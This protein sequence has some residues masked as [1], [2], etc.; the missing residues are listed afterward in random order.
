MKALKTVGSVI[1]VSALSAAMSFAVEP[2]GTQDTLGDTPAVM[3]GAGA[4]GMATVEAVD[5]ESRE[6]SLRLS[7]GQLKSFVLGDEVRNLEQVEVGD[8]VIVEYSAGLIMALDPSGSGVRSRTDR[9]EVGRAE[10]GQ[11][12]AG[13]V[14]RT[15]EAT[16]VI[17]AVDKQAR[18]VT[19]K[20]AKRTVTLPVAEDIDIAKLKVGDQVDAVYQESLAISVRPAPAGK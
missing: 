9:V 17:M 5:M 18:T 6:I 20:G 8:R 16:G 11:K 14:R 4:V 12:P 2:Q 3:I 13:I 7:D 19:L 1:L 15:V 10:P